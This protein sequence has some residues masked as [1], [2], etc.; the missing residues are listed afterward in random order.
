[1]EQK[2]Q[3]ILLNWLNSYTKTEKKLLL[4]STCLQLLATLALI[5][6]ISCIAKILEGFII[7][8]QTKYDLLYPFG[9]L[10]LSVFVRA[11]L[12][13]CKNYINYSFGEKIKL[14]IRR[15]VIEKIEDVGPIYLKTK[16]TGIWSSILLE[17][18]EELQDYYSKYLPQKYIMILIPILILIPVYFFNYIAGIILTI[19]LPLLPLFM[20]LI[21]K[22]MAPISQKNFKALQRLSSIFF[23]SIKNLKTLRLFNQAE[24]QRNKIEIFANDWRKK[25]FQ[26]LKIAFMQSSVLEFFTSFSIAILAI[27]IGFSFLGQFNFGPDV[28]LFT[29][30][31]ILIIAPDFFLPIREFSSFYHA[32]SQALGASDSIYDFITNNNAIK[33]SSKRRSIESGQPISISFKDVVILDD[34]GN[35]I[36]GPLT[37]EIK[38]SSSNAIIGKSGS[39]K[40]TI[41]NTI[42]GY[43]NYKGSIKVN[44]I[45]LHSMDIS[46]FYNLISWI[47]Q[48]PELFQDSVFFNIDLHN[49][50]TKELMCDLVK[51]TQL[52][53]FIDTLPQKEKTILTEDSSNISVGQAQRIAIARAFNKNGSFW[54]LDEPTASLDIRTSNEIFYEIKKRALNGKHTSLISTHDKSIYSNFDN[55]ILIDKGVTKFCGPYSK[56]IEHQQLNIK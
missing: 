35:N 46:S 4:L 39:G 9:L 32:K 15:Q 24:E 14:I 20:V 33:K 23:D 29:G 28:T 44:K 48:N 19:A 31:F 52:E 54:L 40:T 47:P 56:F 7:L 36:I 25:T 21:G 17:Q 53:K 13:F 10:L 5:M 12:V 18:I 30:L 11:L 41:I 34:Q 38:S 42:L 27:F 1:M 22:T 49:E 16:S 37:F 50:T 51:T 43:H 26:T 2:K 55:I 3:K 8:K 45:E 6:Q